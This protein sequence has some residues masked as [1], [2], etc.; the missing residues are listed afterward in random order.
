MS[1]PEKFCAPPASRT[2]AP[3]GVPTAAQP[4]IPA[5][6]LAAHC[7]ILPLGDQAMEEAGDCRR[8]GAAPETRQTCA[9]PSAPARPCCRRPPSAP[10]A[11]SERWPA[12]PS[13]RCT[14]EMAQALSGAP[15][16]QQWHV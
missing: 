12:W 6:C 1:V 2:T 10:P 13:K 5:A 8:P 16:V 9:G 3:V 11:A 14:R 15:P 7:P 4:G